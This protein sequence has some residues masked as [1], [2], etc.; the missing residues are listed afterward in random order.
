[1]YL[2]GIS[3][4]TNANA[5]KKALAARGFYLTSQD[6]IAVCKKATRSPVGHEQL[7]YYVPSVKRLRTALAEHEVDIDDHLTLSLL[8]LVFPSFAGW[9][10]EVRF[11]VEI[12]VQHRNSSLV[13]SLLRQDIEQTLINRLQAHGVRLEHRERDPFGDLRGVTVI[14]A[15]N[16]IAYGFVQR[17]LSSSPI[18]TSLGSAEGRA[19][20]ALLSRREEPAR[21]A[22]IDR[23]F[24]GG[25]TLAA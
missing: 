25:G 24:G 21:P 17:S 4:D 7:D 10:G 9:E 20:L 14:D 1:M 19:Y 22:V 13:G 5:L 8:G 11:S 23:L 2:F 15:D 16:P 12:C 18:Q 6:A 3:L